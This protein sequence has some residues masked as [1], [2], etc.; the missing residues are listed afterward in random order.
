MRLISI[1]L[2]QILIF[3]VRT[4]KTHS[5]KYLR[6]ILTIVTMLCNRAQELVSTAI[7]TLSYLYLKT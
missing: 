3:V 6:S 7:E 5:C 4:L 1:F 2:L